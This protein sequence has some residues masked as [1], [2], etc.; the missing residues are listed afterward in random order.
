MLPL[1]NYFS[2]FVF[3]YGIWS[4]RPRD[5]DLWVLSDIPPSQIY[6][7]LIPHAV[8]QPTKRNDGCLIAKLITTRTFKAAKLR[9]AQAYQITDQLITGNNILKKGGCEGIRS[10][11][12]FKLLITELP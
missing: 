7:F 2:F 11:Y 10:I 9:D 8:S 1:R 4:F 12:A 3:K 6:T 5:T